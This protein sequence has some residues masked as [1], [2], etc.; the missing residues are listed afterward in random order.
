[1]AKRKNC[2]PPGLA[3]RKRQS[4]RVKLSLSPVRGAG[5]VGAVGLQPVDHDPILMVGHG[6][7]LIKKD[8]VAF[9][10]LGDIPEANQ[11]REA[12]TGWLT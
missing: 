12:G 1:V 11:L 7:T 10:P 6:G 4:A 2:A 3:G 9:V 8:G 5:D